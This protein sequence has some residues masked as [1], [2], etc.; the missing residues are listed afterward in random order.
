[1]CVCVRVRKGRGRT[2]GHCT[3]RTWDI[4]D[5]RLVVGIYQT[6]VAPLRDSGR[7]ERYGRFGS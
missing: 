3:T 4:E 1:M 6:K 7:Q 2:T 5:G